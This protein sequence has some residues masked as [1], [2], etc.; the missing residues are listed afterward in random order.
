MTRRKVETRKMVPMP[1]LPEDV[2]ERVA[3][4]P[5]VKGKKEVMLTPKEWAFVQEYVTRDGTMTRT[6]AAIRAGYT[7][8]AAREAITR[9]MDPARSPHVVAAINELRAELAEKYGTNFERHMRDLQ[10]IRDKAIEAGAWSA[11][12][13]AE[14]RRGQALGTIYVDRK[15]VR[16]GTI[17]SMSKEEVM[18]KLEEIKKIYGGPPPTAILEMESRVVEEEAIPVEPQVEFDPGELLDL[19]GLGEERALV[20]KK[21]AAA[22]RQIEAELDDSSSDEIGDA[23]ELRDS[24]PI[25]GAPEFAF[26]SNRVEGS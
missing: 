6:E 20:T 24:G 13:Q 25:G 18:K 1:S 22:F 4:T 5:R 11:A 17:D 21:R 10:T 19:G 16:I 3:K 8:N 23:G 9:L 7:P 2:L 26:R 12:V 14:Y 15:E